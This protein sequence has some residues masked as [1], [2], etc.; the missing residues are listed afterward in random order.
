VWPVGKRESIERLIPLK[1]AAP[2]L[3]VG[4]T[5]DKLSL[6]KKTQVSFTDFEKVKRK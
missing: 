3:R 5:Q 4:A 2:N 6:V 1:T